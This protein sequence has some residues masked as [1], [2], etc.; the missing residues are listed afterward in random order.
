[1]Y[2]FLFSCNQCPA[3]FMSSKTLRSHGCDDISNIR[4]SAAEDNSMWVFPSCKTIEGESE[5]FSERSKTKE[6][7]SNH[8][9][10][11]QFRGTKKWIFV[12]TADVGVW[13]VCQ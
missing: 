3:T 12:S 13:Y 4:S 6:S 5:K 11:N 9:N 10:E 2:P 1:M 7:E 8:F